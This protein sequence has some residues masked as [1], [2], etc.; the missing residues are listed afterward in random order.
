MVVVRP[1]VFLGG[2]A[3]VMWSLSSAV[4]TMVIPRALQ[5]VIPRAVFEVMRGVLRLF[6]GTN[7]TYERRDGVM[8]L[9]GP[10]SMLMLPAVW[11]AIVHAGFSGMYWGLPPSPPIPG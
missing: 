1:A 11:L 3:L 5:S 4:R 6:T 9:L 2:A 10:V 8:V 7:P